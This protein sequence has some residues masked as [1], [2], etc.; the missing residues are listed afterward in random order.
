MDFMH[1]TLANGRPFRTF[2]GIADFARDALAIDISSS[3]GRVVR[4][5]EQLCEWYSKPAIVRSDNGPEFQSHAVQ[6]WARANVSWHFIGPGCPAQ[7]GYIERYSG[8]YRIEVLDADC[9][10]TLTDARAEAQRWMPIYNE[11]W[12]HRAIGSLPPT[13]F[14]RR[15]Q[16]RQS[17][18]SMAALKG[19][20]PRRAW[21]RSGDAAA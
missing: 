17:L 9:F 19:Y 21:N 10:P 15:W 4:M 6:V 3:G 5:L 11:Q 18:L 2:N 14:K 12:S 13:A 7:H 1:D 20:G 8:A 16:E